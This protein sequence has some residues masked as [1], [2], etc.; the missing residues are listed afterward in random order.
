MKALNSYIRRARKKE[1][2]TQEELAAKAGVGLSFVREIES[3][4]PM[5]QLDR[6]NAILA[7]FNKQLD[8]CDKENE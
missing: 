6:L 7:L 8:I 1:G 2:L 3:G 4:K 5:G